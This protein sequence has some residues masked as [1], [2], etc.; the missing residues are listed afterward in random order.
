VTASGQLSVP[1]A[2]ENG[3]AVSGRA[4]VNVLMRLIEDVEPGVA[5]VQVVLG[6]VDD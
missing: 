6:V 5:D 1:A 4:V 3:A 2:C